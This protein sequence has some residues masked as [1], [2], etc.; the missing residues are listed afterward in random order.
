MSVNIYAKWTSPQKILKH[1]YEHYQCD[2][3]THI[4]A[5]FKAI[6]SYRTGLP[7][8]YSIDSVDDGHKDLALFE[9]FEEAMIYVAMNNLSID[10][11]LWAT[12][13]IS[14]VYSLHD[15]GDTLQLFDGRTITLKSQPLE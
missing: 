7:L 10:S 9:T 1:G 3:D 4:Q 11:K 8:Y 13:G 5:I 12:E 2:D 15:E 14:C 6:I